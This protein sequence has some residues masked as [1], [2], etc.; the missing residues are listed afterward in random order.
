MGAMH[1]ESQS[2]G[3]T[4]ITQPLCVVSAATAMVIMPIAYDSIMRNT[5]DISDCH[6]DISAP[7][8][9][10]FFLFFVSHL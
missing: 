10:H 8:R 4:A 6:L 3:H 7:R 2:T 5:Q 1:I 9:G